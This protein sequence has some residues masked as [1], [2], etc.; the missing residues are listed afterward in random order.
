MKDVATREDAIRWIG[1]NQLGRRNLG[2]SRNTA[3][4][5][6]L[7]KQLAEEDWNTVA[8]RTL[9]P[10][11]GWKISARSTNLM[12]YFLYFPIGCCQK[13]DR[14]IKTFFTG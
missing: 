3:F 4:A 12:N 9:P 5:L 2:A 6:E 10:L 7:E 8:D 1:A 13:N 14:N 11:H